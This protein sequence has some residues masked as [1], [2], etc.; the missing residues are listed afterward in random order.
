MISL[1][2]KFISTL[3]IELL[4]I[5]HYCM[6]IIYQIKDHMQRIIFLV[7]AFCFAIYRMIILNF[8]NLNFNIFYIWSLKIVFFLIFH[9]CVV[10]YLIEDLVTM[11]KF[12]VLLF[13]FI[14]HRKTNWL[15]KFLKILTFLLC[16]KNWVLTIM[17]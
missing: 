15:L 14:V 9:I 12:L 17:Y 11:I 8:E 6:H 2:T 13:N 5:F 7:L 3:K 1:N 10:V 16:I 4:S